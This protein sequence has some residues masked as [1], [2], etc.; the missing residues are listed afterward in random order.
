MNSYTLADNVDKNQ[1]KAHLQRVAANFLRDNQN[2]S[3]KA[4]KIK[5]SMKY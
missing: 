2:L 5:H 1:A 3:Q 4:K